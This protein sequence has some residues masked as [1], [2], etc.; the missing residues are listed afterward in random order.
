M[1]LVFPGKT[2]CASCGQL[3]HDAKDVVGFPAFLQ[4]GHPL[5]RFSDAAFHS[6]CFA[7]LPEKPELERLYRRF[8]EIWDNR[9]LDLNSLEEIEE[10]GKQAF[11]EFNGR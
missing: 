1:A 10:W 6:W 7:C 5:Y 9:P 3:I 4:P 2:P 8:R 11:K